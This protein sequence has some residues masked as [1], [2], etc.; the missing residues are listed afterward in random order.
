MPRRT[1]RTAGGR[2]AAV[3][4]GGVALLAALPA[5]AQQFV[6]QVSPGA[7]N[8]QNQQNLQQLQQQLAP[9]PATGPTVTAPRPAPPPAAAPGG[10]GFV[11]RGVRF[12][13]SAFLTEAELQAAAKPFIGRTV[14]LAALQR[15]V[16]DVNALYEQKGIPTSSAVLPRQQVRDGVVH[17]ELVE[18]KLGRVQYGDATPRRQAFIEQRLP[19]QSGT[20]VNV[21][22]LSRQIAIFNRL[23]DTQLHAALQPGSGFGLT[24][25]VLDARPPPRDTLDLFVDNY[26]V[27]STDRNEGGA[28]YRR[29]G[30]LTE[31]DRLT[32]YMLGNN[33]D[34]DG[35]IA[36]NAP[37]NTFGGRI[38]LSYGRNHIHVI[39]G[40][41]EGLGISGD[42]QTGSFDISQPFYATPNWLVSGLLNVSAISSSTTQSG[43]QQS[44]DNTLKGG[45]GMLVSYIDPFRAALATVNYAYGS[46]DFQVV[47]QSRTFNIASG[48]LAASQALPLGFSLVFNGAW[49]ETGARLLAPDLLFELGGAN[50][51]RGYKANVV[52]GNSGYYFNAEVHEDL[53]RWVPK[54]DV[55]GFLDQGAAFAPSP[56]QTELL[57][58]GGGV[59]Y[60]A[61]DRLSLQLSAGAPLTKVSPQQ[62]GAVFYFRVVLHAL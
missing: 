15:L 48:S 10:P 7:I 13:P 5:S 58:M 36:Y 24:D 18:G 6:P 46:T 34:I 22:E 43:F 21:P 52:A 49:Q 41:Y 9:P 27:D 17:V 35:N 25:V 60:T 26:G 54:L 44:K 20:V 59:G 11:L 8:R 38:G 14:D 55:F 16:A 51:V 62:P 50:S 23:N 12:D 40:P 19:L 29:T 32:L 56:S 33:G 47:S 37:A 30:L 1:D 31:D 39:Q 3:A 28:L 57:G 4:A 61:F 42:A 2:A 45:P 53:S